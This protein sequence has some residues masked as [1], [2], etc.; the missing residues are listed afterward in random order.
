MQH[1]CAQ[2][3]PI[4]VEAA[5]EGCKGG[6]VRMTLRPDKDG[7]RLSK[8]YLRVRGAGVMPTF[9]SVRACQA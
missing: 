6:L 2:Q 7:S 9:Y 5:R 1:G 3:K 4:A 8:V